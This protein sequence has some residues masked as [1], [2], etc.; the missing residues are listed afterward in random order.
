MKKNERTLHVLICVLL[1]C[2]FFVNFLAPKKVKAEEKKSS[3]CLF[4]TKT[5]DDPLYEKEQQFNKKISIIKSV[6]GESIDPIALAATVYHRYG[7]DYIYNEEYTENFD[8]GSYRTMWAGFKSNNFDSD[9]LVVSQ[10]QADIINSNRRMDILTLAAIVM[11]DSNHLG[12]YSDACYE[13]GLAGNGL[14]NNTGEYD[15][16]TKSA[17]MKSVNCVFC[18]L[19]DIES[20]LDFINSLFSEDG[21]LVA[22]MTSK[23]KMMDTK[24]VCENGYVGGVYPEVLNY[25]NDDENKQLVKDLRAKEIIDNVEQYRILFGD[26]SNTCAL[27]TALA[28]GEFASWKQYDNRWGDISMGGTPS[29]RR[30]GCLVT[31][32]AIQIARS[33]TQLGALPSGY[34]EFNP[35][36]FVTSLNQNGGFSDG[37]NFTWGGYNTVAPHWKQGKYV[38]DANI[39]DSAKL[40]DVISKELST[41]IGEGDKYQKFIVLNIH[42]YGSTQ[43][44]IAVNGVEN[45]VVKTFDPGD[46]GTTLDESYNGWVVEDYVVYYADDILF[47]QTGS[48][49][50][51]SSC[52]TSSSASVEGLISFLGYVEGATPCNYRGQ[53]EETGYLA[54]DIGDNMGYTAAFG[55]TYYME[56]Y[57]KEVGYDDFIADKDGPDHCNSKVYIDKMM[58]HVISGFMEGVDAYAEAKNVK[59]TDDQRNALT[60]IAHGGGAF[61]E[62]V[63]DALVN[64]S[65]DSD[66]VLAA[67]KKTYNPLPEFRFGLGIRRMAE[68]ELFSTGNYNAEKPYN[69]FDSDAEIQAASKE[70][71]KSHWPTKRDIFVYEGG[72][73]SSSSS[74]SNTNSK[75]AVCVNGRAVDI[76]R[77]GSGLYSCANKNGVTKILFLGNSRTYVENI[78]QKVK[79]FA[80]ADGYSVEITAPNPSTDGG[81]LLS[82]LFYTKADQLGKSYDCVVMQEQSDTYMYSYD[83]FLNGATSIVNKVKSVNPDVK[84]YVRQTWTVR[85]FSGLEQAYSNAE[86]VAQAT[87]SYLILDGKA[88]EKSSGDYGDIELFGDYIHQNRNGAFL[89]AACIYKTLYGKSPVGSSYYGGLSK[90]VAEKLQIVADSI[91]E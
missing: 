76:N 53:G 24:L 40:A 58:P 35:G 75:N 71:I 19:V 68:Y 1:I 81:M 14:I 32:I 28:T 83:E 5:K 4:C 54:Y 33:G 12:T 74:S 51:G 78:P 46:S 16:F 7:Q 82:E 49:T 63:I 29:V 11:I 38:N 25:N 8:E 86:N 9:K 66:E 64:N 45:G 85:D 21:F 37:A 62:Y 17:F 31:S 55:L 57:A 42:H 65:A 69:L 88:F 34:S 39:S 90:E 79:E 22:Q 59:L 41:G 89:S 23:N 47:G 60:S 87:G 15:S 3:F 44:W 67:F 18:G 13:K 26:A 43:H 77:S 27:N 30:F 50:S 20:P 48:S 72:T 73:S 84:T 2:V 36:A 80:E 52:G 70:T 56:P 6:F 10:E 61:E 91:C